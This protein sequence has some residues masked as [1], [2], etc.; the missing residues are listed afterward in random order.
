MDGLERAI[1]IE[2]VH[3]FDHGDGRLGRFATPVQFVSEGADL[4]LSGVFDEE[5]LV[6]DGDKMGDSRSLKTA[7][8]GLGN[9]IGVGGGTADDDAEGDDGEWRGF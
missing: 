6:N 9:E 8:D 5:D 7:G 1:G 4:R 2:R 3:Y